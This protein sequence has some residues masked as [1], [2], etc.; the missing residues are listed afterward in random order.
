MRRTLIIGVV[1]GLLGAVAVAAEPAPAD[2]QALDPYVVDTTLVFL[3]EGPNDV[4]VD[5]PRGRVYVSNPSRDEIVIVDLDTGSV[6]DRRFFPGPS[7][8]DL[9]GDGAHLYVALNASTGIMK[10]DLSDWSTTQVTIPELGDART[11]DVMETDT[12]VVLVSANP[13]GSGLAYIVQYDFST[14]TA[15][16]VADG[17]IIRAAPRFAMDAGT[18]AYVGEGFAPNSLYR[19]DLGAPGLPIVT[20]DPH[21]GVDGSRSLV[22]SPD[23][24]FLVLG[25]G[26]KIDAGTFVSVGS[27]AAGVP[28]LDDAGDVLYVLRRELSGPYT[29]VEVFDADTT[30]AL[31]LWNTDCSLVTRAVK[32]Q[33]S[34]ILAAITP[35]YL[36]LIDSSTAAPPPPQPGPITGVVTDRHTGNTI[37]GVCVDVFPFGQPD[38]L[39]AEVLTSSSGAF[40]IPVPFGTYQVSFVDCA[41]WDYAAEWY[42]PADGILPVVVDTGGADASMA[43]TTGSLMGLV[44]TSQGFWAMSAPRTNLVDGFFFGNPGDFPILGDWDCDGV[45]TPGMYRQSDG[46]V[47]LRNSNT[48]GIADIRFFFGNPGDIPLAGDFNGNGCDTVSIFRPSEA[49]VFIINEL[50]Q[51]DGGLGAADFTYLFGNPGDKPFVGDFDVDFVDTVGLHR[52]STGLVYFRNSHTQGNAD[53]QYIFGDPGDRLVAGNFSGFWEETPAVFRPSDLTFYIRHTNTQ[54]NADRTETWGFTGP[55]WYPVAGVFGLSGADFVAQSNG[56]WRKQIQDSR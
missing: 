55:T 29:T 21:S 15:T 56:G 46:Y 9:S 47:Y 14:D 49:R 54:G 25:G 20:E 52:E 26:Q 51:N 5:V 43:L 41:G 11:W 13:G 27:Y 37:D 18:Y 33:G 28:I 2:A 39:V 16:V 34:P 53:V 23:G 35:T 6:V 40:S 22:V 10:V 42:G 48:Q 8:L 30:N 32:G 24:S 1:V 36:C 45:D 44:D 3:G 38:V 31:E 50:G 4:V 7:G 12:D 17:R 19:L